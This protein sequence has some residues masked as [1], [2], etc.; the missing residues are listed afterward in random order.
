MNRVTKFLATAAAVPVLAMGLAGV[1]SA[2][3]LSTQSTHTGQTTCFNWRWADGNITATIH[4]NNFCTSE[5]SLS[6]W[7]KQGSLLTLRVFTL[8]GGDSGAF[9][10]DGTISSIS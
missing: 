10:G 5:Q 8:S 7:W 4:F 1:A 2:D 3:G 9:K 6:V